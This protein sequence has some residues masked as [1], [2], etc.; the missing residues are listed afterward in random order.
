MNRRALFIVVLVGLLLNT[1]ASRAIQS[2]PK[3]TAA[4]P[5]EV[6]IPFELVNRHVMLKVKVNNSRP[7][8]FV[9]DTGDKYAIIDLDRARELGLNLQGQVKVGGACRKAAAFP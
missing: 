4:A 7:L 3:P 9:L 2:T 1:A 5:S 6:T 8:W